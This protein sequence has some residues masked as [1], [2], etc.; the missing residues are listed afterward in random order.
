MVLPQKKRALV[1]ALL[2]LVAQTSAF[3]AVTGARKSRLV[4]GVH[5]TSKQVSRWVSAPRPRHSVTGL[6]TMA[7]SEA[8]T[9]EAYM[10]KR[11]VEEAGGLSPTLEETSRSAPAVLAEE[12][13]AT[14]DVEPATPEVEATEAALEGQGMGASRVLGNEEAVDEVQGEEEE[15]EVV[16]VEPKARDTILQERVEMEAEQAFS[17][18]KRM[19]DFTSRLK[20]CGCLSFV[21][22]APASSS[23]WNGCLCATLVLQPSVS[24]CPLELPQARAGPPD[25][26]SSNTQT[27]CTGVWV[28]SGESFVSASKSSAC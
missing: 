25:C 13:T 27:T 5:A 20:R 15:E 8:T 11:R 2:C 22:S 17:R 18:S 7:M 16:E 14:A 19:E 26:F 24:V 4:N 10:A 28:Q 3:H 12:P 9:Y 21:F 1:A 6:G 23:Q